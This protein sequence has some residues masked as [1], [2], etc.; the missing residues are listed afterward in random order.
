MSNSTLTDVILILDHSADIASTEAFIIAQINAMIT[1]QQALSLLAYRDVTVT[2]IKFDNLYKF[3]WY[4]IPILEV[5]TLTSAEFADDGGIAIKD[6]IGRGIIDVFDKYQTMLSGDVP[7]NTIFCI[8]S[9][10]V[11]DASLTFRVAAN[12][13]ERLDWQESEHSWDFWYWGTNQVSATEAAKYGIS[14]GHAV[15]FT[16]DNAGVTAAINSAVADSFNSTVSYE[17]L[18]PAPEMEVKQ[19]ATPIVDGVTTYDFSDVKVLDPSSTISFDINNIGPIELIL[20]GTPK[21]VIAGTDAAM[22]VIDESATVSPVAATV[23]TTAFTIVYTPTGLGAHTADIS[24]ANDD[25]TENPYTF[26]LTGNGVDCEMEVEQAAVPIAVGG[27]YD[28]GNITS[29]LP[30]AEI[31]FDI[32]NTGDDDLALS[33]TPKI[34]VSG[35]D[36]AMYVVNETATTTPIAGPAGTTTFTIIFTPTTAGAKVGAISIANN[37]LDENP[38]TFNLTGAGVDLPEIE[39]SQGAT[40]ILNAGSYDFGDVRDGVPTGV[41][42]FTIENIGSADLDLTAGPPMIVVGGADAAMFVKN[43]VAT[44]TPVAALGS[45]TFTINFTPVAIGAKAATI[46]IANNDTDENPFVFDIIGNGIDPEINIKVGSVSIA[47]AG[48][49]D[50]GNV[51][52][53]LPSETIAF[54]IENIGSDDLLLTAGPPLIVIGGAD[55]AMFVHDETST[56]TP[57]VAGGNTTFTMVFTPIG[58]GAKVGTITIA[59]DDATENPYVVNLTGAGVL[60]PEINI[61]EGVTPVPNASTYDFGNITSGLPSSTI[62]FTVENL[63]SANLALSGAPKVVVSG[64]DAAMYVVDEAATTT[65]IAGP[66][67]TTTF[68]I[69]FTPTTAGLKTA[70]FSIANDDTTENPYVVTLNGTGILAPE[71][72][73]RV[74]GAPIA[75]GGT[76]D[77]GDIVNNVPSTTIVFTIDNLGSAELAL[78]GTPKIVVG[79][80]DSTMYAVDEAATVTPVGALAATTFTIIFTPTSSGAKVGTISIDNDDATENPYTFNLTGA[81]VAPEMALEQAA[82]PIAVGGVFDFGNIAAGVPSAVTTFDI[83]NTGDSDLNITG[84]PK[85]VISGTHAAMFVVDETGTTTPIAGPAG[86]TTFTMVF[87]PVGLGART[88]EVS[89]A[90]DDQ[91]EN[92]YTFTLT[93]AGV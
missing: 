50:F 46:T 81:G 21:I 71:I 63:G 90:N 2:L 20:S 55:A 38:Y 62:T 92:P 34:V 51:T 42:T 74:G 73:L 10:G 39:L 79:G 57:V 43:E 14:A 53:A 7:G 6:G 75:V 27:T 17:R 68:T 3:V 72:S 9:Y 80:A 24:I 70:Q 77:F 23:G 54:T 84:T 59:N 49:Y 12:L 28:F 52:T 29:G 47:N 18:L 1:T 36:S 83:D 16:D 56:V 88:A 41:I 37:D 87:T 61:V 48:T 85:V 89:I 64:T 78:T 44:A 33:G 11:D 32:F 58:A 19:G 76:Y 5:P 86:T 35:A 67:G 69:I 60:A 25:F 65:P 8:M 31:T 30:S 22:F 91:D 45:T 26:D 66:A 4:R 13:K 82:V 93:G 40:P 15:D